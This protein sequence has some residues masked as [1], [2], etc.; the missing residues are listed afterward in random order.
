MKKLLFTILA[1]LYC[2]AMNAQDVTF[3]AGGIKYNVTGDN[4]VEVGENS[5]L[6]GSVVIPATVTNPDG[7]KTYNV[8][9]IGSNA[10][11]K[12]GGITSVTIPEGVTYIGHG[13][14]LQTALTSISLPEGLISI[15]ESAFYYCTNLQGDLVI[16]STVKSIGVSAFYYCINL[17]GDLVIPSTVKSIGASAFKM[18][19]K[20]TSVTIKGGSIGEGAFTGCNSL[21][22]LSLQEG[23]TGIGSKAFFLCQNIKS[24]LVIPSTVKSIGECA[25]ESCSSLT[26]VTIK[27]GSIG[28]KAF[29]SCFSI[30]S[31]SLQEGVTSIGAH[32]FSATNYQ[33]DYLII[34][35]TVKSIGECAFVFVPANTV[36]VFALVPPVLG[37]NA[38]GTQSC[39]CYVPDVEKYRKCDG[40]KDY[41]IIKLLTEFRLGDQMYS[42]NETGEHLNKDLTFNDKDL[43][44][45][46]FDFTANKL[47]YSRTFKNANWQPLYV[48]FTMSYDDWVGKFDVA[49]INNFHEY[50]DDEGY[51]VKTE[52]EVRLVKSGKLKPNHPYLIKAHIAD[53]TKAQEI[54]ISSKKMYKSYE[55]SIVCSSVERKYTFTGT[56]RDIT[57]MLTKDYIFLSDGKL[58]KATDDN[59]KLSAQRWY[60]SIESLGSQ[61]DDANTSYAKPMEFDIKLLDDEPTGIDEITVTRTPLKNRSEAIYNLNGMRVSDNY[62]GIVIKNGKKVYQK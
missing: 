57:E 14:F 49:A 1:T 61:I 6:S 8:T 60:L 52:L 50:T 2:M 38:F 32:A 48:P 44:V 11:F 42:L 30:N 40:W 56:Y 31:L 20:L 53:A 22:S 12:N 51:T 47:T 55:N 29:T 59:V 19:S 62:K 21:T 46:S 34:P 13:A 41:N 33:E 18:C 25:F 23:V 37:N 43:Y 17:Q 39:I 45:S 28:D 9:G 35:S 15:G 54:N 24:D 3:T 7:D 26:S 16:P 5:N 27:G 10:F 58:C 36:K 4:T